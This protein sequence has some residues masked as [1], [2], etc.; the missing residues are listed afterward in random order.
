LRLSVSRTDTFDIRERLV[1]V[2]QALPH[3]A[4]R[5]ITFDRGAE[6]TDWPYLQA[7]IGSATWFCNPQSRWQ[8]G[9]VENSNCRARKWLSRDVVPLSITDHDLKEICGRLK[10]RLH[11]RPMLMRA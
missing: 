7:G 1:G 9:V 11:T 10:G 4:L 5:L 8:K 6:F 3:R 2:L